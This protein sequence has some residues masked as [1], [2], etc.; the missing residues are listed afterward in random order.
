MAGG[1]DR[2]WE[3]KTLAAMTAE[4]W[5]SRCD[6]CGKCCVVKLEDVDTGEFHSTDIGCRLLDGRTCRCTDY[7]S[8]KE[9][10]PDCVVLSPDNLGRLP[11]MPSTCAYRLLDEGRPL[12][13]WHPLVTG[14]PG[15][16]HRAGQSV[17]GRVTSEESVAEE[18]YPHHIV[19]W[20]RGGG[21]GGPAAGRK[22]PKGKGGRSDV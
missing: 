13:G 21:A 2:F 5:E 11:W 14:D 3:R 8:R 6:G 7:A 19:D 16:T 9:L 10:V 4:E 15:S 17:M 20:D 12:P 22:R 1:S 18:D